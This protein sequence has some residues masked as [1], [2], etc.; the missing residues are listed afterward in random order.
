MFY[1]ETTE[2]CERVYSVLY[3]N[4][5]LDDLLTSVIDNASYLIEGRFIEMNAWSKEDLELFDMF[6][7]GYMFQDIKKCSVTSVYDDF[8]SRRQALEFNATK[9]C[10]PRLARILSSILRDEEDAVYD[11]LRYENDDELVPIDTKIMRLNDSI[12]KIDNMDCDMKI[13][14]LKGLKRLLDAKKEHQYFDT[15]LLKKYYRDSLSL[16]ELN[17]VSEKVVVD[18]PKVLLKDYVNRNV[19]E[20]YEKNKRI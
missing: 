2:K 11:L 15:E 12:N 19:G 7:P 18:G 4:N 3:N 20:N 16:I 6:N 9:V 10:P 13:D 1:K 5:K 17:M 14:A 8:G